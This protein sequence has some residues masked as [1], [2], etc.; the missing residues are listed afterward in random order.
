MGAGGARIRLDQADTAVACAVR[1]HLAIARDILLAG[2]NAQS[3]LAAG[4]KDR[5]GLQGAIICLMSVA[6][7][8]WRSKI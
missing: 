7:S 8:G 4:C 6:P 3:A 1:V 5:Y 2:L